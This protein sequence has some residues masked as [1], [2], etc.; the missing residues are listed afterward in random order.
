MAALQLQVAGMRLAVR[1]FCFNTNKKGVL[2]AGNENFYSPCVGQVTD[3]VLDC[4]V[5]HA[6]LF[7]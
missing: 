1:D 2:F 6:T 5:A 3:W 4:A 7:S